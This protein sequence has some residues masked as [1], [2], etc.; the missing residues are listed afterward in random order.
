MV[1]KIRGLIADGGLGVGDSLPTER[2]L[3][4]RFQASRNTVREAMRILKAYGV[5]SVR[6]KVGATIIDDRMER[7]L[8]LFS[9]NTLD[10]SRRA[11]NDIQG[12][13]RLIEVGSVDTIFEQMRPADI[14]EMRRINELLRNS[15]S[16]VEAS[17]MDF[18]FHLRIVS[19]LDNRAV[20]DVYGIMKPVII[21]I[22]ERAKELHNFT[23]ET[24]EQHAAVVDALEQRDRIR[25]QYALQSHL[26]IGIAAFE[27]LTEEGLP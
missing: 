11:F 24:F 9:F 6:P 12:F 10:I 22:M 18:R 15:T 1:L 8:D 3:C 27:D 26:N 7:A 13:R 4:E 23:G 20:R 14:E 5:V 2:E 17:E 19:I 16:I 25:Y 21:R